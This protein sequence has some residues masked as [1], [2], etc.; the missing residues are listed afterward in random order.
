MLSLVSVSRLSLEAVVPASAFA[1]CRSAAMRLRCEELANRPHPEQSDRTIAELFEDERAE[2][3]PLGRAFD[4]YVEKT[5]G[6]QQSWPGPSA[7]LAGGPSGTEQAE[8]LEITRKYH[9]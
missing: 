1:D 4:G 6:R 3:R 9:L 8:A 2:L 7:K 5:D